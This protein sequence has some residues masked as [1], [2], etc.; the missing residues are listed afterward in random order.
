M[1][2]KVKAHQ[3]K[4]KKLMAEHALLIAQDQASCTHLN[5]RG[6]PK[7]KVVRDGSNIAKGQCEYCGDIIITDKKI[8]D[9]DVVD[10]SAVIVRS[11]FAL[12]RMAESRGEISLSKSTIKNMI[13]VDATI[14]REL[15]DTFKDI[16]DALKDSGKKK[17]K[18]KKK[19]K[20]SNK[21]NKRSRYL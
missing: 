18:H 6:L 12:I 2:S 11:A 21:K 7:L 8:M 3:K 14:L 19:G 9:A 16:D 10:E 5:K 13:A 20:K 17:G 4:M 15:G 1:G